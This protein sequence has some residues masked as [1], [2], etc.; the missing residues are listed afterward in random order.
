MIRFGGQLMAMARLAVS[1]LVSLA[2]VTAS[3]S[4]ADRV[5]LV[6]GNSA[7]TSVPALPNPVRDAAAIADKLSDAGFE[8]VL[9]ENLN[10]MD[11][12]RSLQLFKSNAASAKVALVYYAGHGIEVNRVNYF[13][14]VDAK[15]A[16]DTDVVFEAVQME[17]ALNAVAQAADLSLVIVDAC[18]NNPFVATMTRE[19]GTRSVGRGLSAIE[20]SGNMLVAYSAKEGTVALDGSGGNSPYATAL[21]EALSAPN[22]EIGQL[23]RQVRDDVLEATNGMQE[24]FTYGSL[25]SKEIFLNAN[26]QPDPPAAP[27]P[28]APAAVAA[29]AAAAGGSQSDMFELALWGLASNTNRIE[30]Y[31]E[32]LRQFPS[33]RFAFFAQQRLDSLMQETP[34]EGIE[35]AT[36]AP[37]TAPT[38]SPVL[39]PEPAPVP[40][41]TPEPAVTAEPA[42]VT[43]LVDPGIPAEL[44]REQTRL[45]QEALTILGFDPG[46]RDGVHGARTAQ[47]VTRYQLSLNLPATG[48]LTI[49][50]YATLIASVSEAQLAEL[51][52]LQPVKVA[53]AKVKAP[54]AA[55]Q[56]V[57][58]APAAKQ[59]D[60]D[61]YTGYGTLMPSGKRCT[62]RADLCEAGWD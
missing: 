62:M 45:S 42:P 29:G 27:P 24:P 56:P 21:A 40:A 11:M 28:A 23:F 55:A 43:R 61:G 53:R 58:P 18:R 14:P 20:P 35:I 46:G 47:A 12:L 51:R 44:S 34:P 7:Y 26:A 13:V 50:Q 59:A 4:G 57:A 2:A 19:L 60:D 3:A 10:Q 16:A 37:A 8:V 25:S 33:G 52:Q 9:L 41:P 48:Q 39:V 38:P 6:I 36:A 54:A 5:A 17:F 49:H 1:V 30:G 15:L 22:L 32:Y 31:E